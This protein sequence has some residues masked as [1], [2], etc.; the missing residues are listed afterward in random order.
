MR[1]SIICLNVE[2]KTSHAIFLEEIN[3]MIM[4]A[5]GIIVVL[6][7]ITNENTYVNYA[8]INITMK[9]IIAIRNNPF[10]ELYFIHS[11]YC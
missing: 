5:Y 1:E 4:G 10:I 11:L 7:K 2:V 8:I 9:Y 3:N 6:G